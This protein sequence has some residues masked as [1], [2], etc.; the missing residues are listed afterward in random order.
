MARAEKAA[1][2][3]MD[4]ILAS[5]R[6]IIAD[7]PAGKSNDSKSGA[8]ATAKPA[9]PMPGPAPV[10][11][12]VAAGATDS[13]AA[14]EDGKADID[15]ILDMADSDSPKPAGESAL[16]PVGRDVPSWLFPGPKKNDGAAADKRDGKADLAAKAGPGLAAFAK[17]DVL[18]KADADRN[19]AAKAEAPKSESAKFDASRSPAAGGEPAK[20]ETIKAEAP[21]QFFGAATGSRDV[22]ADDQSASASRSPGKSG[23]EPDL[24]SVVPRRPGN[25][26]PFLGGGDGR[27]PQPRFPDRLRRAAASAGISNPVPVPTPAEP[28]RLAMTGDEVT[29]VTGLSS[30]T[31]EQKSGDGV[32]PG[33]VA[34]NKA[35]P[36]AREP[37][38]TPMKNGF[39]RPKAAVEPVAD[40]APVAGEAV[41][42][43]DV[44][45]GGDAD[46]PLSVD[47]LPKMPVMPSDVKATPAE[48]APIASAA[49]AGTEKPAEPAVAETKSPAES[50]AKAASPPM[51]PAFAFG[52]AGGVG[53]TRASVPPARVEP[54]VKADLPVPVDVPEV[55]TGGGGAVAKPTVLGDRGRLAKPAAPAEAVATMAQAGSVRT[56]EDTVVD[57]LRPMI[58]QWLDD[59]MP[60]MVEK[61]LRIELASSVKSKLDQPKH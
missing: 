19:E 36:A 53:S 21:R 26:E 27:S 11:P 14:A 13:K 57:L 2:P 1:E 56:L 37:E 3:S 5:I 15:D 24:G 52:G 61:A 23:M 22:S 28:T 18:A 35:G 6:K 49:A 48:R 44:A 50:V 46:P 60:R 7:E 12:S 41:K 42:A 29:A 55:E 54:A 32:T 39:D 34:A 45:S 58:R 47:D 8:S 30:G 33:S 20:P 59:N 31:A 9:W 4:E 51:Q 10:A 43:A 40:N 16:P 38:P 25:E 17:A